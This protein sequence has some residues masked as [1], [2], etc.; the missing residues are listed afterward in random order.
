M[1]PDSQVEEAVEIYHDETYQSM[2]WYFSSHNLTLALIWAPFLLKAEIKNLGH[3]EY[4]IQLH[5]DAL[6]DTWTSQYN[7]YDYIL[8][9]G[10]PW[11]L[12]TT[13]FWENNTIIGC[14]D[15][16]GK[17]LKELGMDYSYQKALELTFHFITT[18][19]HKLRVVFRTWTLDHF[20]YGE[21]YDGG[22]CNRTEPY[23]EG[24]FSGDPV[25]QVVRG[26]EIAEF[27][28]AA[29]IGSE[30]GTRLELLDIYHLSLLRPDGHPGPYR[31]LHPDI[32][33]RPQN[34]CLHWCLPGP[35]DTWNDLLMEIVLNEGDQRFSS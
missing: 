10:G 24:E 1:S 27:E 17:N 19:D 16:P 35:V 4:D 18:S 9:S 5:L 20:E 32:S 28:K 8:M 12:K 30:H 11:F 34:D 14:H 21:W 15:C 29:A 26:L 33:K 13:I 31:K 22:I 25:D 23:K 3:S 2:T 7:K 6:D